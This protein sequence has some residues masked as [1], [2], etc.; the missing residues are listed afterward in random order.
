MEGPVGVSEF[1]GHGQ[2]GLVNN[3]P[4][5]LEHADDSATGKAAAPRQA[6]AL[7]ATH[8]Q[9]R[10]GRGE[11]LETRTQARRRSL[12]DIAL[13]RV[14]SD[15]VPRRSEAAAFQQAGGRP[16]PA[17]AVCGCPELGRC[18]LPGRQAGRLWAFQGGRLLLLGC[19]W[20]LP[21]RLFR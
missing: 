6:Y 8:C 15:A 21:L 9:P 18:V 7:T 2:R 4:R 19:G 16:A 14:L 13:C 20:G 5:M 12:V 11:W 17:L 3:R 1:E 10:V